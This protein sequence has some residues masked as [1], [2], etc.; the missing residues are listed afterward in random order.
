MLQLPVIAQQPDMGLD[1]L[2]NQAKH[3]WPAHRQSAV[4]LDH[5]PSIPATHSSVC[6][7]FTCLY[8]HTSMH[9]FLCSSISCVH[10][11][12][13]VSH[14]YLSVHFQVHPSIATH[15]SFHMPL[16]YKFIYPSHHIVSF[17][18]TCW[19]WCAIISL[20]PPLWDY[21]PLLLLLFQQKDITDLSGFLCLSN[22]PLILHSVRV[23]LSLTT[24]LCI[25]DETRKLRLHLSISYQAIMDL[26][27]GSLLPVLYSSAFLLLSAKSL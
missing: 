26:I 11:R 3:S 16:L 13:H 22:H 27:T 7:S 25:L 14:P 17:L 5:Y 9:Q 10:L 2:Q 21:R 8:I 15:T 6:N 1:K 18:R 24:L 4:P 23:S 12:R 20:S 19:R